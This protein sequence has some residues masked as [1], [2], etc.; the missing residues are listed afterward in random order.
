ML[1]GVHMWIS[2]E[3]PTK[4]NM[5]GG[6]C[7]SGSQRRERWVMSCPHPSKLGCV[8]HLGELLV[9]GSMVSGLD[10]GYLQARF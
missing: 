8:A 1:M 3:R 10:I 4:D 6:A 7:L 5:G 2:L 9:G